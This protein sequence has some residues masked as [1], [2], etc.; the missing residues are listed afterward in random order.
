MTCDSLKRTGIRETPVDVF[1]QFV[2]DRMLSMHN[3]S[4]VSKLG[5]WSMPNKCVASGECLVDQNKWSLRAAPSV[6]S[7]MGFY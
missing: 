2:V 3:K 1:E 7:G 5:F 6:W 4:V